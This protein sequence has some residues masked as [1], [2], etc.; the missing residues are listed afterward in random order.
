MAESL[1]VTFTGEA[2]TITSTLGSIIESIGTTVA[3]IFKFIDPAPNSNMV[4]V[5]L[6][7]GGELLSLLSTK[8]GGSAAK[9]TTPKALVMMF[10]EAWD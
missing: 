9:E 5:D 10:S 8:L 4:S 2:G 6:L 7:A 1:A 3:P